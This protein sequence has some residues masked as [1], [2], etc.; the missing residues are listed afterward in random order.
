MRKN[1]HPLEISPSKKAPIEEEIESSSNINLT[2]TET[3]KD[4]ASRN[5]KDYDCWENDLKPE[6]WAD[7]Y[8]NTPPPHGKAPIYQGGEYVWADIELIK[9]D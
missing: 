1:P 2:T 8:I 6:L 9:Y 4:G 3:N 7:K 5:L